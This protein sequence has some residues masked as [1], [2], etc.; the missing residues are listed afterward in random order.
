MYRIN[1]EGRG[2]IA[3][4]LRGPRIFGDKPR[5][6]LSRRD[7]GQGRRTEAWA[8]GAEARGRGILAERQNPEAEARGAD[9]ECRSSEAAGR[10]PWG[11]EAPEG[12]WAKNS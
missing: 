2:F 6:R 9:S 7:G 12:F 3:N 5:G 8:G 10:S 4:K 1:H 11:E